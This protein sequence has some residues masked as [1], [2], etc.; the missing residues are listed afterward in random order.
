V[1]LLGKTSA[2]DADKLAAL[3]DMG[4]ETVNRLGYSSLAGA[5]GPYSF[6]QAQPLLAVGAG[7]RYCATGLDGS[8]L[9]GMLTAGHHAADCAGVME[10]RQIGDL[11]D[12][13][14]HDAMCHMT[15]S[16]G[17]AVCSQWHA[18]CHD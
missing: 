11:L 8:M 17:S 6:M 7:G 13:G 2:R 10:L 15:C 1:Q 5:Y 12:A 4:F 14:K 9:A 18:S 3:A 16:L